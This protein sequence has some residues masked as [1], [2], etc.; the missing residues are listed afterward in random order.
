MLIKLKL[1]LTNGASVEKLKF[2]NKESVSYTSVFI[3]KT[4]TFP[5]N[6]NSSAKKN[7]FC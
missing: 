5:L 1:K 7:S 3:Q 6:K 4:F 2:S